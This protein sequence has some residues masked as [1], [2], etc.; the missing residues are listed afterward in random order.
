M[1]KYFMF[2]CLVVIGVVGTLYANSV[3]NLYDRPDVEYFSD[4]KKDYLSSLSANTEN[5]YDND[6]VSFAFQLFKEEVAKTLGKEAKEL[7]SKSAGESEQVQMIYYRN[8]LAEHAFEDYRDYLI[9]ELERKSQETGRKIIK[10]VD[11]CWDCTKV[12]KQ[13]REKLGCVNTRTYYRLD[14]G[15]LDSEKCVIPDDLP[16]KD[17]VDWEREHACFYPDGFED[18]WIVVDED[19]FCPGFGDRSAISD[20]NAFFDSVSDDTHIVYSVT[21][22]QS[23][24]KNDLERVDL[25]MDRKISVYSDWHNWRNQEIQDMRDGKYAYDPNCD[26]FGRKGPCIRGSNDGRKWKSSAIPATSIYGRTMNFDSVGA[27]RWEKN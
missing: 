27:V 13:I 20:V 17:I 25:H 24:T 1:N 5:I 15:E 16:F 3:P 4:E 11:E 18:W 21:L 2:F 22:V 23:G 9:K 6:D 10:E 26:F 14:R 19:M 12:A 8:A 7:E